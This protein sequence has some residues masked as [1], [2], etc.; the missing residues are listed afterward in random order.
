MICYGLGDEH[1]EAVEE[2]KKKQ[3]HLL[4]CQLQ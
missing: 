1:L 4:G 3:G 2:A